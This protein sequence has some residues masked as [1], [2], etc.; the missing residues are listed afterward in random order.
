M[1]SKNILTAARLRE[2]VRYDPETG[3]LWWIE[4]KQGRSFKKPAGQYSGK[5]YPQIIIEGQYHYIHV[6]AW[7]WMTGEWP[8]NEVDHRYGDKHDNRWSKLRAATSAQQK[9]NS[10][11]YQNN[12]SGHPGVCWDKNRNKWLVRVGTKYIGRFDAFDEAVKVR[13]EASEVMFGDFKRPSK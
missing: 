8:V 11:P 4:P 12:T 1:A 2:I 5:K 3:F 9:M 6:L 13:E 10:G 7:V